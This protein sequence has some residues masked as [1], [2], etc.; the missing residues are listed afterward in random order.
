MSERRWTLHSLDLMKIILTAV[1][2]RDQLEVKMIIQAR[3]N[4]GLI[5]VIAVEGVRNTQP[6]VYFEARQDLLTN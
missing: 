4:D 2:H 6:C 3:G 5:R 1:L